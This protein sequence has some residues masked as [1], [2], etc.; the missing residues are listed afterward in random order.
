[1]IRLII[2]KNKDKRKKIIYISGKQTS[3][4]LTLIL[5]SKKFNIKKVVAYESQKITSWDKSILNKIKFNQISYISFF[6]KRTA[7]AFNQLVN[8]YKLRRYLFNVVCISFSSEIE[9][10]LKKNNF[11]NYYL[12]S[13][14]NGESFVKLLNSLN[15]K[16]QG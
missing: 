12:P 6:S 4:N 8:K 14:P 3:V 2:K 15:S 10:L 16:D 1:M 7:E 9:N 13:K 5:K 11:R